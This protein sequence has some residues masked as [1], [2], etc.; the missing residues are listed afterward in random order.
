MK[1]LITGV[2]GFIGSKIASKFVMMGYEVI[3]IDDLSNGD[4]KNIPSG[5]KFLQLDLSDPNNIGEIPQDCEIILHLAGQSSGEISFDNP[6]A[7]LNK[8]T[9]STLNLIQYGIKNSCKKIIYASSM[10]VYGDTPDKPVSEKYQTRPLSCYGISK[11]TSEHYL[12]IY[13]NKLPFISLRMFN[14]YGPGQDLKNLRQG[15]VSIYMA[16][17]IEN[18]LIQ[19]KGSVDRYRDFVYI[20]DVVL[21]WY[22]LALN[23]SR[24]LI[25]NLGSGRKTYI[26]DLLKH[27][28][29]LVDC[30]Y[31]SKGTTP[32][33]QAG[34]YADNSL[35]LNTI[36]DFKFTNLE[37]GLTNF[38]NSI[39]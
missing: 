37:E 26:I 39:N 30:E 9:S 1:V 32:G 34:I 2:A 6:I 4:K 38:Y 21:I 24:N 12:K 27:I 25:L 14:I 28:E 29:K 15:M 23:N 20:D 13:A 33:D 10:S 22:K 8:N 5:I 7:D 11:L 3:G 36:G 16:Q 31:F 18:N 35:L 17:A 19:V